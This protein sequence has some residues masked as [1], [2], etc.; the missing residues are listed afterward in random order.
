[1]IYFIV[2]MTIKTKKRKSPTESATKY[3]IG[4]KN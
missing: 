1:M 4:T 2:Y 3:K